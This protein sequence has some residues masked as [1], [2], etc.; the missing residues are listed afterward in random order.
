MLQDI[1]AACRQIAPDGKNSQ[2]AS[3]TGH[4]GTRGSSKNDFRPAF[5]RIGTGVP[6]SHQGVA[7]LGH[8]GE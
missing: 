3:R 2:L 6:R 4:R 1:E 5:E 8:Q 7:R